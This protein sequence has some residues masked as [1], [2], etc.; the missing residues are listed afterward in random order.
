M[1]MVLW[2]P[3]EDAALLKLWPTKDW[4]AISNGLPGRSHWSIKSRA[5]ALGVR[6]RPCMFLERELSSMSLP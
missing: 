5:S 4:E 6:R 2:R 3:E 1:S